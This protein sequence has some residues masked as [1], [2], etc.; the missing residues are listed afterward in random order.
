MRT[1][2]ILLRDRADRQTPV[3]KHHST[4]TMGNLDTNLTSDGKNAHAPTKAPAN[5]LGDLGKLP[6]ELRDMV[7][8][9]VLAT[10]LKRNV[11]MFGNVAEDKAEVEA[12]LSKPYFCLPY[13][14][15]VSSAIRKDITPVA[16]RNSHIIV[17]GYRKAHRLTDC[18]SANDA[19]GSVGSLELRGINNIRTV[20]G[21]IDKFPALQRLYLALSMRVLAQIEHRNGVPIAD[22]TAKV[23]QKY[24]LEKLLL[25]TAL[26]CVTLDEFEPD[27]CRRKEV[28]KGI[29]LRGLGRWLT[30]ECE[31]RK[32]DMQLRLVLTCSAACNK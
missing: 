25:C 1:G 28:D 17:R 5:G 23:V 3:A 8:E 13:I 20:L 26:R 27:G 22:S 4:K 18:L 15:R 7:Y 2:H 12:Q 24:R 16:L 6:R 32:V 10:A 30:N 29:S 11:M 14:S 31:K 21:G 19:F 9:A